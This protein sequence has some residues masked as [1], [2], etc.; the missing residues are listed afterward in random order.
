MFTGLIEGVGALTARESRGGDA[1]LHVAVG[2]L[3]FVDVRLGESIAVNGVCL[4]V[5]AFDDTSFAVDVSNETL[6]LTTL[7]QLAE[8]AAL[9]LERAMKA[10]DRLGG[11]LVSGHVDGV[12][13]V[14][15]VW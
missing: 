11:H 12:G 15:Q 1:R 2:T 4:T 7:G 10:D 8:G 5:V 9:N 3:P 13:R 14:T 6:A